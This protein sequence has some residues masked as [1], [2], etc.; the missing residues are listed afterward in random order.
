M[1]PP[2][3]EYSDRN[4]RMLGIFWQLL[5]RDTEILGIP[6]VACIGGE[7][8]S[9]GWGHTQ[10]DQFLSEHRGCNEFNIMH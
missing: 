4:E 7:L 2:C 1:V 5:K 8:C 3:E 9:E 6:R 10:A